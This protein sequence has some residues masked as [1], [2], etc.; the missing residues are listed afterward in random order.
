MSDKVLLAVG[1][2]LL[3]LVIYAGA[4]AVGLKLRRRLF[5]GPAR[6]AWEL[7]RRDLS[8]ADRQRVR[9]ATGRRRP[10]GRSALALPQLVYS[11]YVTYQA[12][13]S[14]LRRRPLRLGLSAAYVAIAALQFAVGAADPQSRVRDF[15]YGALFAVFAVLF[16][17]MMPRLLDRSERKMKRLRRQVRDRYPDW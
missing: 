5:A 15:V 6:D 14:P 10:V 2:P 17:T 11:R 7:A 1:I 3:I 4:F 13:R 9:W 8:L 16:G 12:E